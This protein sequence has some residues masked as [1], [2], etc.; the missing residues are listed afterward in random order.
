MKIDDSA[1][2][3][4]KLLPL[5]TAAGKPAAA[6]APAEPVRPV[7]ADK[8]SL[9]GTAKVASTRDAPIDVAKVERVR[10]EIARG[11]F[12]IDADRIAGDMLAGAR[13]LLAHKR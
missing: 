13:E 5:Q 7:K 2:N 9:S 1:S 3:T 6:A 10:D 4:N 12:R 11:A 8:V